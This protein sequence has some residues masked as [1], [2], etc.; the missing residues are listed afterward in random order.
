MHEVLNLQEVLQ[1][2]RNQLGGLAPPRPVLGKCLSCSNLARKLASLV[3]GIRMVVVTAT[4][5]S[6]LAADMVGCGHHCFGSHSLM[7]AELDW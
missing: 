2:P 4:S 3:L 7:A 6:S 1:E 5:S